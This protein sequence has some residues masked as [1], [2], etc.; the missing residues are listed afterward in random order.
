M[1]DYYTVRVAAG[2]AAASAT[3]RSIALLISPLNGRT[4]SQ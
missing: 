2:R 1:R 3:A 4:M